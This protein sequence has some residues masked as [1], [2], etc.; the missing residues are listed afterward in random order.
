MINS[1]FVGI[2]YSESF[3]VNT[4]LL[5]MRDTFHQMTA[6]MAATVAHS[7]VVSK[8]FARSPTQW[9]IP[10]TPQMGAGP[11][12]D[13]LTLVVDADTFHIFFYLTLSVTNR[14]QF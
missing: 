1:F 13:T 10:D 7:I 4:E 14:P 12:R 2:P 11:V 8:A 9:N 6:A 3:P 5:S